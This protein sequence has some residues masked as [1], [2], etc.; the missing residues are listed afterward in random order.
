VP[1]ERIDAGVVEPENEPKRA[2]DDDDDDGPS[3]TRTKSYPLSVLIDAKIRL[4][5]G[6]P[7]RFQAQFALFW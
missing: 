4:T 2:D 6:E 3:Y 7:E 5:C 1:V